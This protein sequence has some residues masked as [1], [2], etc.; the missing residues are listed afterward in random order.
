MRGGV[1]EPGINFHLGNHFYSAAFRDMTQD[2]IFKEKDTLLAFLSHEIR[3]PV[4]AIIA[5]SQFLFDQTKNEVFFFF[6]VTQSIF[7]SPSLLRLLMM[8]ILQLKCYTQ[9]L[10]IRLIMFKSI[11]G[12]FDL[13][14][15]FNLSL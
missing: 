14:G 7:L 1:K 8:F 5:G 13:N 12:T 10:Q 6:F 3:N 4:Q 2:K 15:R 9:L 11:P